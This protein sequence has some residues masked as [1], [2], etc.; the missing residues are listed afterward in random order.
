MSATT[1]AAGTGTSAGEPRGIVARRLQPY[2][3]F[4]VVV[5]LWLAFGAALVVDPGA[6]GSLW[7]AIRGLWLPVQAAVW[8]LALPWMIGLW[9]WQTAWA[10]WLRLLLAAGIAVANV[11]AFFPRNASGPFTGRLGATESATNR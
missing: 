2:V 3:V 9:I 8:V 7:H 4:P 6:L 1:T 11:Y 10:P 5:L